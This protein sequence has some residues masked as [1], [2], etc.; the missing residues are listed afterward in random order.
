MQTIITN[1]LKK[2]LGKCLPYLPVLIICILSLCLF[3]KLV[4]DVL[5]Y[6]R[7]TE[8]DLLLNS[9][10]ILLWNPILDKTMLFITNIVSPLPIIILS[11]FLFLFL[12]YRK[13]YQKFF[14]L[15]FSLI[16]GLLSEVIVKFITHRARPN[17][18]LIQVTR[19]SF[20]SG[21][22]T[23]SI[24][25]F[26]FLIYCFKDDIKNKILKIMFITI[27]IILFFLI[28]FSRIYLDAHWFSDVLAGFSL[29]LFWLS[30]IILVFS[31]KKKNYSK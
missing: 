2:R 16:A 8:I 4:E 12:I 6:D 19:Y 26:L 28:G 22:A 1:K 24:I 17:N 30:L 15:A 3:I 20:P 29:G 14:V 25:F 10:V 23:L 13:R 9:K 18:S 5:T 7:I 21:H 27:N 11:F 31:I